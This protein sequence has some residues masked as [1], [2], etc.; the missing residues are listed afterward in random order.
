[1]LCISG[2]YIKICS[3]ILTRPHAC[4]FVNTFGYI[5]VS[6]HHIFSVN[7][8]V[9]P[10]RTSW[11]DFQCPIHYTSRT[12]N[13]SVLPMGIYAFNMVFKFRGL[14]THNFEIFL[15]VANFARVGLKNLVWSLFNSLNYGV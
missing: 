6:K 15:C 11:A 5:I 4:L 1:M 12:T 8:N 10:K 14:Y 7:E 13:S 2:F 3:I 9:K